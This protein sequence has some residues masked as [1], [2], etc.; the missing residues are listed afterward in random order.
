VIQCNIGDITAR[1]EAEQKHKDLEKLVQQSQR[2]EGIGR[3]AGGIAH[4]LY[5]LLTVILGCAG[6]SG[7]TSGSSPSCRRT[8]GRPGVTGGRWSR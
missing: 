1:K 6:P 3:L 5:N 8:S 7:R 2:L 4:D